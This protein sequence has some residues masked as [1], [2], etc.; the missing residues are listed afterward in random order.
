MGFQG[1]TDRLE[2]RLGG[3]AL[4]V[5]LAL[6]DL[7][8][9]PPDRGKPRLGSAEKRAGVLIRRDG[10]C[11]QLGE[12]RR[13][14]RRPDRGDLPA[15]PRAG[16]PAQGGEHAHDDDD[17]QGGET[18]DPGERPAEHSHGAEDFLRPAYCFPVYRS[19]IPESGL[20]LQAVGARSAAWWRNEGRRP[21]ASPRA[22]R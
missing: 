18:Y 21:A 7:G 19:T 1:R 5:R 6:A 22:A 16:N 11:G 15:D 13:V 3:P 17:R 8:Q 12:R 10:P 4:L 14:A 9:L 2:L 20:G